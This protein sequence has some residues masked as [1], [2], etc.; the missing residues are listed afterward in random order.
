M[1]PGKLNASGFC[2]GWTLDQ[3]GQIPSGVG[4]VGARNPGS[5]KLGAAG[6]S[7]VVH[8]LVKEIDQEVCVENC[9]SF[10]D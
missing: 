5:G 1:K 7:L 2:R 6:C 8:R 9:G 4:N 10:E 3:L